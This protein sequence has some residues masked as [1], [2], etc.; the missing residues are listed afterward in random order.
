MRFRAR[1][2]VR[3]PRRPPA[4]ETASSAAE[5]AAAARVLDERLPQVAFAEVGP[6]RVDEDELRIG[7]LPEEEVGNAQ[8]AGRAN[9]EIRLGHLRRIQPRSDRVLVDVARI[10]P[11]LD[12]PAG[13]LDD[14]VTAAV[15]ERDPE[16]E[17][18]VLVGL[19]LEGCHLRL[20]LGARSV[21]ATDEARV[22]ALALQIRELTLDRL[23]EDL[24]QRIDLV[25]RAR[26]VLSRERVHAERLDA[27]V[28]RSLDGPPQRTGPGPMAGRD[29]KPSP[30]RPAAVPVHDDRD[31]PRDVRKA[32]FAHRLEGAER[33]QSRQEAQG[34]FWR[35]RPP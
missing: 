22:D 21:A 34:S 6:E 7:E 20:E 24:H 31:R 15:V 1:S 26:P 18:L 2:E 5:A 19:P 29:G 28:D 35:F 3:P 32:L 4:R 13:R 8:L 12:D 33:P 16:L 23:D 27:E 17:P 9:E 10:Q 25:R 11:L 30:P 14:L